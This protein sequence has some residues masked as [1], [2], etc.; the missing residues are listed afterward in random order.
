MVEQF[1]AQELKAFE[2]IKK[3]QAEG[4]LNKSFVQPTTTTSGVAVYNL[5]TPAK[6]LYPVTTPIRNMIP[7]MTKREAGIAANWRFFTSL[8]FTKGQ[9]VFIDGQKSDILSEQTVY[10]TAYFK[11][12]GVD[13]NS[14][15]EAYF[16]SRGFGGQDTLSYMTL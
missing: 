14:T 2:D 1:S 7:R 12:L 6:L 3:I 15:Y 4:D 10:K 13:N 16:A 5:E 9:G 8:N 11:G